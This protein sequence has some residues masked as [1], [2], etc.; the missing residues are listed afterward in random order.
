MTQAPTLRPR[1]TATKAVGYLA[2]GT[3]TGLAT[4]H[5]TIYTIGYLSTPDTPVSAYLLGGV[6]IA[7]MALVFAGAALALT[8][9]SGP[10]RWRRTLLALCWTAA[11]LLTLQTLMITLG[12]P[13]LLIQPAGPGPWSLI[14]GPAFAVF[15]WRS[16]RRRPRT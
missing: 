15:A 9:T 5:L 4:A 1:S 2:A 13:G 16:R 7:V 10:Q 14:G 6:A 3:A 8:R 12:E 11:L